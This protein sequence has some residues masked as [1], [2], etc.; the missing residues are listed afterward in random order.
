V[1]APLST[2][3]TCDPGPGTL[4]LVQT[5]G[6]FAAS[7]G[8]LVITQQ[9]TPVVGDLGFYSASNARVTGK[10][11]IFAIKIDTGVTENMCVYLHTSGAVVSNTAMGAYFISNTVNARTAGGLNLGSTPLVEDASKS[12]F[13]IMRSTGGFLIYNDI[14]VHVYSALSSAMFAGLMS[15]SGNVTMNN[16]RIAN[17]GSPWNNNYG[18]VTNRLATPSA[19]DTT[20]SLADAHIE[21]TWTAVTGETLNLMTRRTD[22][23]NC[24]IVRADQT[25]S[26]IYLYEKQAGVETE[27]GAVGGVATTFTNGIA[28]RI[29]ILQEG[30]TIKVRV[31]DA[32]KIT[33]AS[34][35]FN[36]TAT[37]VKT[38]KAGVDLVT[39]PRVLSGTLLSVLNAYASP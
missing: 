20:T 27:R 33:Y 28:Y 39:W 23:D 26:K 30:N 7:S 15:Y 2:P 21:F 34:A 6:S 35:A 16:F 24:W 31:D 8:Q 11:L 3:R 32:L 29:Y 10:A 17:L 38:D 36:N 18:A 14:L 22:D 5:D 4:T 12:V 19:N 25:N 13:I 37:G 9:T 1:V